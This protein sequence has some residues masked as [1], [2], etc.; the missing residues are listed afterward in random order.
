MH[1]HLTFTSFTSSLPIHTELQEFMK[2]RNTKLHV[3]LGYDMHLHKSAKFNMMTNN[4][5][6]V[7]MFLW[8]IMK[9]ITT[10]STVTEFFI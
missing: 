9:N 4:V 8:L 1:Y 3:N 7:S 10:T 2:L 6:P 5:P